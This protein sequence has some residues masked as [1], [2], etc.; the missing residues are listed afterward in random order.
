VITWR[1]SSHLVPYEK[2]VSFMEHQISGIQKEILPE[3]VW[4]LEH[5]P[6]YTA[7]TSAKPEDLHDTGIFPVYQTGRGGQYTY[8]G[9]GQRIAYVMINLTERG[10]DVRVFVN[11]LEQWI[12]DTLAVFGIQG[13]RRKGRVGIW[14]VQGNRDCKIAAIGVRLRQ[15]VSYHG[16]AIN[17]NPELDHY[18][19]IV[20]CGLPDYGVTSLEDLGCQI[21]ME[22]LDAT[23][24]QQWKQNVYLKG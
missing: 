11:A 19:G 4:L 18:K 12:M 20:P 3:M 1:S 15:W 10:R 13:S 23:L 2:A 9:P 22:N 21:T 6:I 8:H 16:I 17:L 5:P 24:R 14:V 7:G